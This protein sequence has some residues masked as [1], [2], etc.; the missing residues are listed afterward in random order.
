[1]RRGGGSMV[2]HDG[3]PDMER[4]GDPRGV[5]PCG[6]DRGTVA[7]GGA[8]GRAASRSVCL[9]TA[10]AGAGFTWRQ[11]RAAFRYELLR[12]W[13]TWTS[14]STA[15]RRRSELDARGQPVHRVHLP[16]PWVVDEISETDSSDGPA[17][18]PGR[19]RSRC[20]AEDP[21]GGGYHPPRAAPSGGSRRPMR[22][23]KPRIRRR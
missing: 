4:T 9:P 21:G 10:C 3:R 11:R 17:G 19:D 14:R 15:E 7:A 23:P 5:G 1:M 2:R 16:D 8:S 6:I 13:V 22:K 12:S 20:L 18:E